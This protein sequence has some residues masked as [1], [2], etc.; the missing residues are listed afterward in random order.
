MSVLQGYRGLSQGAAPAGPVR[1]PLARI[2]LFELRTGLGGPTTL[3][4]AAPCATRPVTP[5]SVRQ[6]CGLGRAGA[7]PPGSARGG[8]ERRVDRTERRIQIE[9]VRQ[10][11]LRG[12]AIAELRVDHPG[13][14]EHAR[15]V[16]VGGRAP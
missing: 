16:G 9:R 7:A 11:A 6:L 8:G 5:V 3:D 2:A 12:R 15:V 14:E 13:A 4:M 1:H 10:V